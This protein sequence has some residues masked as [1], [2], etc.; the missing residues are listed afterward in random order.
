M[1]MMYQKIL[2]NLLED[3][4][5]VESLTHVKKCCRTEHH[6]DN[7]CYAVYL[8]DG[9]MF[10]METKLVFWYKF[11]LMDNVHQLAL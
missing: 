2:T 7:A 1:C 4:H 3:S 8:L 5:S 10:P 6:A 11:D 9:G